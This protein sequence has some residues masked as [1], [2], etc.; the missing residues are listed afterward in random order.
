[1]NK[2]DI[3]D[4]TAMRSGVAKGI[5]GRA[6]DQLIGF[7]LTQ[8][9]PPGRLVQ[10]ENICSKYHQIYMESVRA[11]DCVCDKQSSND[12]APLRPSP[13]R[14]RLCRGSMSLIEIQRHHTFKCSWDFAM[15]QLNSNA[16]MQPARSEMNYFF[17][18]VV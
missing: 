17:G 10:Q 6:A 8:V 18:M 3:S 13:C 15:H 16:L 4:R 1:M 5:S 9:W 2:R 7:L 12:N 11:S 14:P